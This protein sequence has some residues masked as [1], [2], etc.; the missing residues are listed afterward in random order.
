V[1]ALQVQRAAGIR[2]DLVLSSKARSALASRLLSVAA[3][4]GTRQCARRAAHPRVAG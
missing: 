3:S 2:T 1:L 4:C